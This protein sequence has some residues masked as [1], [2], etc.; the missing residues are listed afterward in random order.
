MISYEK[1]HE[2]VKDHLPSAG[3]E[4][5][6]FI[7]SLGRILA[8][9][10]KSDMDMPPFDKSAV[11]GYAC[12]MDDLSMP[13]KV[14]EVI[15]AGSSGRSS[16]SRGECAKIMTGA[17]VPEGADWVFM[18]EEATEVDRQVK[19][20]GKPGKSN[21]S[22]KGEDIRKGETVL[23][24]GKVLRPQD[25]AVLATVGATSVFVR[26]K[27]KV[28]IISTGNELVEP[29]L[30][31]SMSQI[32][33]SNA[34]QLVAQA[35]RSG[36]EA[37]YYG[38]AIDDEEVTYRFILSAIR[39]CEIVLLTGGVSMGDFDMVPGVLKRAGVNILFDSVAVQP[40]KPTTF[41][42]HEKG[43]VFAL[44]GNPVSS[45]VQFELF[46]R[47]VI[48]RSMDPGWM[49]D[50]TRLPMAVSYHRKRNDRLA[51]IPV[52]ISGGEVHPVEY[53]GSAHINS[54]PQAD[55]LIPV[56]VG[57]VKLEKGE[58]VDVRQI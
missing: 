57:V 46:V 42:V 36:A 41:G 15:Q 17:P 47:P 20:T 2:I 1:A 40:G 13:L 55:G 29:H 35:L 10:V 3:R 31:P 7:D 50:V 22:K 26:T 58:L 32:R 21:I 51:W 4:R 54:L 14:N 30:K 48:Q 9:D 19:F 5:I 16:I 23:K 24:A 44:P 11:D 49:P 56:P 8:E 33:N 6:N 38:V 53:H 45:F 34:Y 37:L 52:K 28:G 12:R 43:M 25:I 39:E 27:P 18:V